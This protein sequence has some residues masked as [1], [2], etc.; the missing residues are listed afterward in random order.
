MIEAGA[1]FSLPFRKPQRNLLKYRFL[2]HYFDLIM[3]FLFSDFYIRFVTLK[4]LDREGEETCD[5]GS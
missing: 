1:I 3:F 5:D 4:V 2:H